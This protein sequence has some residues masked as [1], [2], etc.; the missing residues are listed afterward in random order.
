MQSA[1][2]NMPLLAA[3]SWDALATVALAQPMG[4]AQVSAAEGRL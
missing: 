4:Q 3:T 1:R 2:L